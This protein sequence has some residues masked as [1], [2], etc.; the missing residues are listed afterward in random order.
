MVLIDGGAQISSI[1]RKWVDEMGLPV[2]E[3]ENLV[4]IIQAGGSILDYEGYTE[5]T[6][7]SDQLPELNLSFPVLVV[8][9]QEYHDSV[10]LALGTKTLYHIHD[11]GILDKAK[12]LPTSWKFANEDIKLKKQLEGQPDKPLGFAK[13]R[14][15][16]GVKIGP[17]EAKEIN[18]MAKV[19]S[20]DMSVNVLVEPCE[21]SKL[22]PGLEVQYSY[23]DITPGS[24]K[25]SVSVKNHTDRTITIQKGT[26]IGSIFC[27][28]RVPKILNHA[29]KVSKLEKDIENSKQTNKTNPNSTQSPNS[30]ERQPQSHSEKVDWI[31]EKLNLSGMSEWPMDLQAKAKDLLVSY[32]DIFSKSDMDMG[33]TRLVKH[34][35][36]LT[37]YTPFKQ[38]YRRIPPHLYDEVRAHLK[39]MLELGAIRKSLS[40][41]S[42]P[43]VLVRK[44][45]GKLRFCKDL[46]KLNQRT[47]RDNYSLPNIDHMLEQLEG[48]EWFCTLDLKSGYW[49][50][51]LTEESKPYTAFTCGPLG[52]FECEK[53]PFGASNA[54]A[55]FQRL[56]ENCLGDLNLRWCVVYLDDIIVY[57]KTPEELL[58]GLGNVF[59]N[60]RKAGLKLKPS[61]CN[62]FKEKINFLGH[63]VCKE[64]IST[65]PEKVQAIQDWPIP[66]T[67]HDVRSFLGFVGYYRKFIQ[68]FSSI[69]KQLNSLFEGFENTKQAN[70]KQTIIWGSEQEAFDALKRACVSAPILGYPIIGKPFILHTDASLDGLG[71]V[72]YQKDKEGK[73]RVIAYASRSLSKSERNYATHRLEFLALKWAITEKFKDYLYGGTF[74]V[75]TDNNP[76]TYIL[77][78]AKLD[79]TTQRWIADLASFQF[80]I[81]YRSGKSNIDADALS[82]IKWPESC[83]EILTNAQ[84]WVKIPKECVLACFQG[85]KLPFGFIEIIARS[86]HVLPMPGSKDSGMTEGDW[87]REQQSDPQLVQLYDLLMSGYYLDNKKKHILK[88]FPLV[89]PYLKNIKQMEIKEDLIYRKV[90]SFN[91]GA[92]KTCLWQLVM[93]QQLIEKALTGCHDQV[94]HLGRDR[95]LSLLRER[96]YWPSLYKDTIEHLDSCRKCKLRKSQVPKAKLVPIQSSRPMELVQLDYLCLEPCKGQVENVLV[97]TDHF[98][99]HA[100]AFPTKSQTAKVTAKVLWHNF[101]CHYGFPEKFISDQGRNFESQLIADLC[102]LAKVK[103]IRTSPYHPMTNGQC[104]RFNRTLCDMLGTLETEEKADWK[105][106]IHTH[107]YNC[108]RNSSTGYSPFFLMFGRHPRLPVDVAFGIHRIGE[109][110]TFSTSKYVDWL[111]RRLAHAYKKAKTFADKESDRQKVLFD[112]RSK[113]LRLEPGDLCLV[114]KTAWQSRHKIQNRLC[115]CLP[116]H[117]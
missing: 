3:L 77:T 6:I 79:A 59:E 117:L 104:E 105:A 9:Y 49:Q 69:A 68:G 93:P 114:R 57:G 18:C 112:R 23:T 92:I 46:R 72:L 8:P 100:Q 115:D 29:I 98:T 19:K 95:T 25:V 15:K 39:E 89:E 30:D 82:R 110:V 34:H 27:A 36:N 91:Q 41:W 11:S 86:A 54:P 37:D 5:V 43:I 28:N 116:T 76:L 113:D 102:K 50:V 35:I 44:K 99:R 4:E 66:K 13:S 85:V 106:F 55:T 84:L 90:V 22:P 24:S 2:Y 80:T 32:S 75:F 45:D 42:S 74:E 47:V 40:P 71:A 53:M 65:C 17:N 88:K 61:K 107:A 73:I 21:V 31:L 10:P 33:T 51:E 1:S 81:N 20:N 97:V 67:I 94:G 78:S 14:G 108:T 12:D 87:K 83:N 56:M 103:K 109:G 7:T 64:G 26:K 96:F 101:I 111:Q 38:R 62:F 70:K 63:T 60:L 48:A 58:E 16:K 52:F